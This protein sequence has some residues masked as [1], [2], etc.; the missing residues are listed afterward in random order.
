MRVDYEYVGRLW[1]MRV[2]DYEYTGRIWV[3][4]ESIMIKRVDFEYAGGL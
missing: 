3:W 1:F 2:V 4:D